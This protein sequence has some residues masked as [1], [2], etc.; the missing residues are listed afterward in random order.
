M[1]F[2]ELINEGADGAYLEY[3]HLMERYLWLTLSY[4]MT[5]LLTMDGEFDEANHS[6]KQVT[7]Y[8]PEDFDGRY[9]MEFIH[10]DDREKSLAEFQKLTTSDMATKTFSF[11]FLCKDGTYRRL[12]WNVAFSP[13]HNRFFCVVK[14]V[15]EPGVGATMHAAYHDVLTGLPNRLY[16]TDRIPARLDK[17][18][19]EGQPLAVMFL[20][21]DGFKAVND[22]YGHRAGDWLLKGVAGRL[23]DIVGDSG[24]AFRLGGDEFVIFLFGAERDKASAVAAQVVG[25]LAEPF[26][27]ENT[28]LKVGAS[29]GICLFPEN[30]EDAE[31]LIERADQ[32]MYLVKRKGKGSFAFYSEDG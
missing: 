15:T 25:T 19:A 3:Y 23:V 27:L 10:F 11:R 32:A 24:K 18:R 31:T 5:A 16:L 14:D 2:H 21:L 6:W 8:A 26:V 1:E 12:H 22:T 13:D 30:G 29:L 9:L 17:A 28:E 4:D 20:D 7:G